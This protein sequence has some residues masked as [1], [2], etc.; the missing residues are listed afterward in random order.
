[1]L[2]TLA[3]CTAVLVFD[4]S[5]A[6]LVGTHGVSTVLCTLATDTAFHV[7]HKILAAVVGARG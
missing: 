1:M 4:R 7:K 6:P 2:R 3:P 5:L